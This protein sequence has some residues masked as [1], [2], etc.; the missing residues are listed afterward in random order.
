[1]KDKTPASER[2]PMRM[3][4]GEESLGSNTDIGVKLRALYGAVQDEPIPERLLDLLEQLDVA[5]QKSK[6]VPSRS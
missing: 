2:A 5:E 3:R 1:M 6:H 4:R